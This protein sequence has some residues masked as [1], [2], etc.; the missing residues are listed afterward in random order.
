MS[1]AYRTAATPKRDG[2]EPRGRS[3]QSA[4]TEIHHTGR[5]AGRGSQLLPDHS[6]SHRHTMLLHPIEHYN[7]ADRLGLTCM[8][9]LACYNCSVSAEPQVPSLLPVNINQG[10]FADE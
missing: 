9:L 6:E 7:M 10:C 8:E 5:K 2:G 4:A 3:R 1:P